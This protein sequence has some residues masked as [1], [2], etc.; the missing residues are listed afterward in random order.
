VVYPL[1][2]LFKKFLFGPF[3]CARNRLTVI[4]RR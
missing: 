3:V 4:A 2:F 1:I